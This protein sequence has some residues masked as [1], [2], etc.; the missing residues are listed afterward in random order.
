[1][2]ADTAVESLVIESIV[3]LME[4]LNLSNRKTSTEGKHE[5]IK[6]KRLHILQFRPVRR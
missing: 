5:T 6:C 3:G 4:M 1:M 2:F